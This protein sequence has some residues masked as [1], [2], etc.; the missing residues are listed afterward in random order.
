M[1]AK[2]Q[3]AQNK[4]TRNT[5]PFEMYNETGIPTKLSPSLKKKKTL[6]VHK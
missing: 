5:Y 1:L 4:I 2:V 3:I 6:C